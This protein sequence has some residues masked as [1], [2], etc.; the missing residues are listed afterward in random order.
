MIPLEQSECSNVIV[1][2]DCVCHV[3]EDNAEEEGGN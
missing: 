2:G 3:R 1:L